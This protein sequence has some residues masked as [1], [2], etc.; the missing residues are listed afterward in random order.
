MLKAIRKG[1]KSIQDLIMK[2]PAL[3]LLLLIII[4]ILIYMSRREDFR[5][6]M[7]DLKKEL[8]SKDF[9]YVCCADSYSKGP[10]L[11]KQCVGGSDGR[12]MYYKYKS[13]KADAHITSG[14]YNDYIVHAP[15]SYIRFSDNKLYKLISRDASKKP[16]D[17]RIVKMND[18][19][20][21]AQSNIPVQY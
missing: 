3:A 13:E 19:Y 18:L 2:N 7:P 1:L 12:T 17:C 4:A 20:E 21:D 16:E 9:G 11:I 10:I 6:I 8:S 5:F 14:L 15:G